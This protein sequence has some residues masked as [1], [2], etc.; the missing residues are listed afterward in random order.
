MNKLD[1]YFFMLYNY[2]FIIN[3]IKEQGVRKNGQ[4]KEE[5]RKEERKK[6]RML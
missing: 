1:F 4:E 6:E 5:G 2:M 3:Y